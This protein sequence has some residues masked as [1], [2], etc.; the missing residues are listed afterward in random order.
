QTAL[1][2]AGFPTLVNSVRVKFA[3]EIPPDAERVT[4]RLE[5]QGAGVL[6][7][8]EAGGEVFAL[9]AAGL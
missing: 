8:V 6:F 3:K 9:G 5:K 2:R 7:S 4:V 1:A